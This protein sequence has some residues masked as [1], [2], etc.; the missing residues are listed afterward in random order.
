MISYKLI[1]IKLLLQPK[2]ES[3]QEA[4]LTREKPQWPPFAAGKARVV[5]RR[6][7]AAISPPKPFE[8]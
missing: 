1:H 6:S 4:W 8:R 3:I 2:V 7:D 5:S